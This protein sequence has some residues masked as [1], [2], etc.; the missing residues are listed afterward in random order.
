MNILANENVGGPVIEA[1]RERG[2]SVVW[3]KETMPGAR[4]AEVLTRAQ[5]EQRL[6][7]TLDKDFG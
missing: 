3:V 2:H 7:V 4:D 6:V 1:L 5:S